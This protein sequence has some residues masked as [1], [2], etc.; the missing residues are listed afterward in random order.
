[1]GSE[2][3]IRDRFILAQEAQALDERSQEELGTYR[4]DMLLQDSLRLKA[5]VDH[6][7]ATLALSQAEF[8][9]KKAEPDIRVVGDFV[10]DFNTPDNRGVGVPVTNTSGEVVKARATTTTNINGTIIDTTDPTKPK[11]VY[12]DPR[13]KYEI[14][15]GQFVDMS[16]GKPV[17]VMTIPK[18]GVFKEYNLSLIHI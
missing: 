8:D 3:C 17:P 14:V 2:M 18:Q 5:T 4:T 10:M 11:I 12:Q 9:L 1:M 16:S 7:A 15:E 13:T 6:Q